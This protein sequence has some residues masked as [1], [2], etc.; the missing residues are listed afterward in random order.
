VEFDGSVWVE[1]VPEAGWICYLTELDPG[2]DALFSD[3]GGDHWELRPVIITS[4]L[5]LADI[6]SNTHVQIDAHISSTSNPHSVTKA[7]VGLSDV[8]NVD[9][10]D[11][12]NLTSGVLDDA[13]V[14][15]SN[16]TQHEG[17]I[18]HQNIS[19]AGTNDHAAIDSHIADTN[20]PHQVT[21]SQTLAAEP[22]TDITIAELEQLTDGS[23]ADSLHQH[24]SVR[25]VAGTSKAGITGSGEFEVTV[26]SVVRMLLNSSGDLQLSGYPLNIRDDGT[27]ADQKVLTSNASGG[28]EL[29]KVVPYG[30]M[31]TNTAGGVNNTTTLTP[32][33]TLN[34]TIAEDGEYPIDWSYTWSLNATNSDF[35]AQLVLDTVPPSSADIIMDHVQ[36]PQDS[37]GGGIALPNLNP[38]PATIN[39]G[40]DQRMPASGFTSRSL[41]AGDYSLTL[42]IACSAAGNE[43]AIYQGNLRVGHQV[44][45]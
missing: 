15:E 32:L 13:R 35:I 10:T 37:G 17:A 14:Q 44:N 30:V 4:H 7:Q 39:T 41:T 26:A 42:S 33:M 43:A 12:S 8:P 38:P 21:F 9:T 19:G 18:E 23:N 20:N 31:E 22:G 34:F 28:V 40:T 16:V 6:G 3:D 11:A 5:D 2:Q 36:E 45:V 27:V 25:N 24:A 29:R 1:Q